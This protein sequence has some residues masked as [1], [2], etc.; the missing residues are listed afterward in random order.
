MIE[1][2]GI[3]KI[4]KK[5]E[6]RKHK[7]YRP[8]P[9]ITFKALDQVSFTCHPGRIFTLIGPNGAGKTTAL[10]IIASMLKPSQG[11][12]RVAGIDIS[13]DARQARAKLGFLT[14]S[15]GL[16]DRLTPRETLKYFGALHM[17][18]PKTIRSRMGE[19]IDRLAIGEFADR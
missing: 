16:Y 12:V 17:V 14:G 10:R 18:K 15:T 4:F 3:S 6:G 9:K 8:A 5:A 1:L 11:T 13:K 19:L 2:N 7:V